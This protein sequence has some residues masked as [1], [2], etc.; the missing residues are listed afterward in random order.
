[1]AIEFTT[2][3]APEKVNPYIET[4]QALAEKNDENAAVVL[5]V[6]V[7]NAQREQFL[8]QRAANKIGKTAR[9]RNKDESTVKEGKPDEDG[10]KTKSGEVKLTFTLTEKHKTRR[11]KS[12]E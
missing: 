2:F 8:F 11:G 10:N 3:E 4:V 6:D 12:A 7:N 9:L 1:M 5:T